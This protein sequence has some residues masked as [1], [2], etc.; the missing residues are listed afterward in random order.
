MD[1]LKS[2]RFMV[3][4]LDTAV[5]IA[6]HFWQGADAIFLIGALQPVALAVI[7]SYTVEGTA[8]IK[9]GLMWKG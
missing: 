3:L 9:A 1:L 5:S 8:R 7:V 2:R 4:V 6:L